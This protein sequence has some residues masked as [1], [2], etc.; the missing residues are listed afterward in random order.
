MIS[1]FYFKL[2]DCFIGNGVVIYFVIG[3]VLFVDKYK[4][5]IGKDY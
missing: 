4:L 1:S 2:S 3:Y 5:V